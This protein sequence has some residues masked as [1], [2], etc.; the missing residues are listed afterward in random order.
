M[1]TVVRT[2]LPIPV[3][4]GLEGMT[5]TEIEALP[6]EPPQANLVKSM[7]RKLDRVLIEDDALSAPSKLPA[8]QGGGRADQGLHYVDGADG[9]LAVH[10][11]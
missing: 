2:H 8:P 5:L 11:C 1:G 3:Y 4:P 7:F 10:D 9:R 6:D